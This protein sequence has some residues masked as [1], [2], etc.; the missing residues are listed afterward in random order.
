MSYDNIVTCHYYKPWAE[1]LPLPH[2][3]PHGCQSHLAIPMHTHFVAH[4]FYFADLW[5]PLQS[6]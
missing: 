3:S 5:H 2:R 1:I 6:K 4:Q